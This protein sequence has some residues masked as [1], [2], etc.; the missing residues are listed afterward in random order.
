MD[1]ESHPR[2]ALGP[3]RGLGDRVD[4]AVFAA[5]GPG[6][7]DEDDEQEGEAAGEL[8]Q[9]TRELVALG[10]RL[11]KRGG[12]RRARCGPRLRAP[13]R[14]G[15]RMS[16][17]RVSHVPTISAPGWPT[18]RV[19]EKFQTPVD[20]I[21][22]GYLLLMMRAAR[23]TLLLLAC[24]LA[25]VADSVAAPAGEPAG[26]A[27][28]EPATVSFV[29]ERPLELDLADLRT[30][31]A[32][33]VTVRNDLDRAQT[34]S[35]Q[36][37]YRMNYRDPGITGLF[38][39]TSSTPRLIG[40]GRTAAVSFEL[41]P[42]PRPDPRPGT[43]EAVLIASGESGGL[44]RRELTIDAAP[45]GTEAPSRRRPARPTGSAPTTRSTSPWSASTTCRRCSPASPRSSSSPRSPCSACSLSR[46][47]PGAGA[48][49]TGGQR[50]LLLSA[51]ALALAGVVVAIANPP[52]EGPAAHAISTRPIE[53]DPSVRD[54]VRGTVAG[55]EGA[56]APLVV[57]GGELRPQGLRS[58]ASFDGSYD[59]S[60]AEQGRRGRCGG[61]RPRLLAL[62]A[63]RPPARAR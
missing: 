57:S 53:V 45:R 36:L 31:D 30:R 60:P 9:A 26:G 24:A 48:G 6:V 28:S 18:L 29:G 47:G 10:L 51:A 49:W 43:Y 12:G 39:S 3:L 58:A 40:A 20:I 23:L 19:V 32:L 56:I 5:L 61:R 34:V 8:Q 44:A 1:R 21:K 17:R 54:G 37:T 4:L 52:G 59:L 63:A 7:G 55:E 41:T 50:A 2:G 27:Q 13:C 62:R 46:P 25:P 14:A 35:L 22:I 33:A 38:S 42:P 11:G 15:E 16:S